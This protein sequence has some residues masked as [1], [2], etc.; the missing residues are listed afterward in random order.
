MSNLTQGAAYEKVAQAK[1]KVQ[2]VLRFREEIEEEVI[3]LLK[4]Q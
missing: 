4:K 1:F 2:E 3:D